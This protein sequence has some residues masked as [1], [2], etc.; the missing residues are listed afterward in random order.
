VVVAVWT[1]ALKNAHGTRPAS[2]NNGKY[3]IDSALSRIEKTRVYAP[4]STSGL[5]SVHTSPRIEPR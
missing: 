4:I 3:S 5:I 2:T 1:D